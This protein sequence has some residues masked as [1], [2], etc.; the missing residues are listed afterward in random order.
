MAA[1]GICILKQWFFN[2]VEPLPQS[3]ALFPEEKRCF[4]EA[5]TES[6]TSLDL[7]YYLN[8]LITRDIFMFNS[9][10]KVLC[11]KRI[12]CHQQWK[13]RPC[14]RQERMQWPDI[15][16][17]RGARDKDNHILVIMSLEFSYSNEMR[18]TKLNLQVCGIFFSQLNMLYK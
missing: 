15:W 3:F 16:H 8:K 5:S 1:R 7:F 9:E 10:L 6:S 17:K 14:C 18:P 11:S 12:M 4:P 13:F 2:T